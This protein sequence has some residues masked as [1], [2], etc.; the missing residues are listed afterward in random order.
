MDNI[1]GPDG[2]STDL[3]EL[4]FYCELCTTDS[5]TFNLRLVSS[6]CIKAK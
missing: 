4:F 2:L 6:A 1:Y 5:I 3:V